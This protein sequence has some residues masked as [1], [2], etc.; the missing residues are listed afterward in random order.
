VD[1]DEKFYELVEWERGADAYVAASLRLLEQQPE[2]AA[3][4]GLVLDD[5]SPEELEELKE[6]F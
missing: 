1:F 5:L 6:T 2:R 4:L 3:E